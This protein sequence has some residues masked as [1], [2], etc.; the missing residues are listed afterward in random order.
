MDLAP[1]DFRDVSPILR[2]LVVEDDPRIRSQIADHLARRGHIVLQAASAD[3]ALVLL[4]QDGS[5]VDCVFSDVQMPGRHDGVGLAR[6]IFRHRPG[7]AVLLTSANF[8]VEDLEPELR[9]VLP[10]LEKPYR[11]EA[12]EEGMA[13][14][15]ATARSSQFP[16]LAN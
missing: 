12:V 9:A 16:R 8:R 7:L 4:Q 14:L 1:S 10:V 3:E 13:S 5:A 2:V 11:G 6:W 15:M